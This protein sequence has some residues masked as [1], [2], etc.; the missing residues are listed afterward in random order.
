[1]GPAFACQHLTEPGQSRFL[2]VRESL[3]NARSVWSQVQEVLFCRHLRATKARPGCGG[4][5]SVW[6][7]WGFLR[8]GTEFVRELFRRFRRLRQDMDAR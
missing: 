6:S 3:G 1:M 5:W 7:P 8:Q 2:D 4:Y